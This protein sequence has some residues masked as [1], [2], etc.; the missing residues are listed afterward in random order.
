MSAT[1]TAT[2]HSARFARVFARSYLAGVLGEPPHKVADLKRTLDK[3]GRQQVALALRNTLRA[4][5]CVGA[6]RHLFP[7]IVMR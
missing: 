4:V 3:K 1:A 2:A 7:L 6:G 5:R